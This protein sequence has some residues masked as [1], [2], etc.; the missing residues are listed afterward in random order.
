MMCPICSEELEA[1]ITFGCRAFN[2]CFE[3]NY[4]TEPEKFKTDESID[5]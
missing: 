5:D 1:A 3:C 2:V 4:L